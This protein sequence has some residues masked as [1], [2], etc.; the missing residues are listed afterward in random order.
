MGP[1]GKQPC[2]YKA[3]FGLLSN[4][5]YEYIQKHPFRSRFSPCSLVWSCNQFISQMWLISVMA[6]KTGHCS[7]NHVSDRIKIK[8]TIQPFPEVQIISKE[9][10][11]ERGHPSYIWAWSSKQS[12]PFSK[13]TVRQWKG[14]GEPGPVD[15]SSS[16]GV[17]LNFRDRKHYSGRPQLWQLPVDVWKQPPRTPRPLSSRCASLVLWPEK[18]PAT[19]SI[20]F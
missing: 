2:P 13:V 1:R 10:G 12:P 16:R 9:C 14:P 20:I 6:V 19:P 18:Y 5:L 11:S 7:W 17:Q 3:L 8:Y 15:I 4:T